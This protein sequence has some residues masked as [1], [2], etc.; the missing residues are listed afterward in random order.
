MGSG[1]SLTSLSASRGPPW[2][3]RTYKLAVFSVVVVVV[4]VVVD[5]G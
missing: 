5:F 4:V 1:S 2:S 3:G